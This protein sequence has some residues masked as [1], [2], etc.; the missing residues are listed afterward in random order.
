LAM[1]LLIT[2]RQDSKRKNPRFPPAL[3][4]LRLYETTTR[5]QLATRAADA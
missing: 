5:W 1:D 4:L 2:S 3:S